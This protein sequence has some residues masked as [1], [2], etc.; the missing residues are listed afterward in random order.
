MRQTRSKTLRENSG[1]TRTGVPDTED[2]QQ[3]LVSL[4]RQAS[5][6]SNKL[7]AKNNLNALNVR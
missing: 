2:K 3:S 5:L 7:A 1:A 6:S 4:S